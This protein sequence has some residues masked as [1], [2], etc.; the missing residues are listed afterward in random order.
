MM[1]KLSPRIKAMKKIGGSKVRFNEVAT[2]VVVVLK[3]TTS[4]NTASWYTS[5]E[6][7]RFRKGR[8]PP[9]DLE[10]SLE[11]AAKSPSRK[12]S[13]EHILSTTTEEAH[14]EQM[15]PQHGSKTPARIPHYS[16][17]LYMQSALTHSSRRSHGASQRQR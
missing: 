10:L 6:L 14:P 9:A 5:D 16:T 2:K 12:Q 3:N 15:P 8:D 11:P 1:P 7:K 4:Q 17:M 13:S